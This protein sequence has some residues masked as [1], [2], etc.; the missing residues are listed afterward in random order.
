MS[1][2]YQFKDC[3]TFEAQNM[4]NVIKISKMPT[5][6]QPHFAYALASC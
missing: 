3:A 1:I 5:F 6:F 4:P 2:I